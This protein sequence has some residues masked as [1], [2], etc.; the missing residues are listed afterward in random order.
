LVAGPRW[1]HDSRKEWPTDRRS[2]PVQ[3]VTIT[4]LLDYW[5]RVPV[6]FNLEM[7]LPKHGGSS[8]TQRKGYVHRLKP[9]PEDS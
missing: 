1:V 8:G 3:L 9:L 7:L 6:E 5:K 2:G 4:G